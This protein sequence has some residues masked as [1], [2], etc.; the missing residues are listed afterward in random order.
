METQERTR[1][2]AKQDSTLA[3]LAMLQFLNSLA[4]LSNVRP[5]AS[6]AE[7]C[8]PVLSGIV[9]AALFGMVGL[10]VSR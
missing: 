2:P 8:M 5:L 1:L 9:A 6:L 3:V 10:E 7:S 4:V